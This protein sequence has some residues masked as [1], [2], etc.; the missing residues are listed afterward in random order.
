[1]GIFDWA[2]RLF[3]GQ[4]KTPRCYLC[5]EEGHIREMELV[6]GVIVDMERW[7]KPWSPTQGCYRCAKCSRLVCYTHSDNRKPCKCGAKEWIRS[8]YIQRE[9]DNG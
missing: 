4:P 1:M 8:T 3:G 6:R 9:L 7:D 5:E 2:L